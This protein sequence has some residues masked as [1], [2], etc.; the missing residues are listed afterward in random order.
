MCPHQFV[1]MI[2]HISWDRGEV[3]V[4]AMDT[5]LVDPLPPMGFQEQLVA[6]GPPYER[7]AAWVHNGGMARSERDLR[8]ALS[9]FL[10]GSVSA[11]PVRAEIA[12]SWQRVASRGLQP[13][14]F[15]PPYD[16]ELEQG[17]RLERAAAPVMNQLGDDLA[18][19]E[20]SL[21]LTDERAH[22]IDRR[23]SDARLQMRLDQILLAPGFYY[24][25]DGVGTN[26]IGSALAARG[27][28]FVRGAEHFA[29]A[30]VD[31]ACA[32]APITDHRNGRVLGVID[33]TCPATSA[34]SL[35]LPFA[36]QAAWEIEQRL[37]EDASAVE[38][39]LHEQFLN[40]RRR[41][42]GPLALVGEYT[43]MPNPAA[44]RIVA[45]SD[46]VLLWDWASQMIATGGR[47]SRD[48]SLANGAAL[49]EAWE[50]V[51]DGGTMVGALIQLRALGSQPSGE[52]RGVRSSD[53]PT[54][55]W[56][57]LTESEH[58]VADLVAEGLT[59]REAATRLLLSP[60]TVDAHLRHIFRKLGI[61]SRVELARLVT[62]HS[63]SGVPAAS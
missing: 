15:D 55:G 58:S 22:V 33:I 13:E 29:D 5:K 20:S 6:V 62:E 21:L 39:V 59:N 56:N 19:T 8:E 46:H 37:L 60:H 52:D 2:A 53:R 40:A 23:V 17:S 25:E 10:T 28:A 9:S 45:P 18:G 24:A 16:P 49:I 44:A 7:P 61:R 63:Q 43:M 50:P 11:R 1:G 12:K 3:G 4:T 42:K 54:F 34:S 26:G 32:G 48:L 35:M 36:K 30:L 31:M 38:R 47:S 51:R 57:S 27:P 41:V 14:R